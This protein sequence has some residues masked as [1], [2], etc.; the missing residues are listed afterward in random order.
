MFT[1]ANQSIIRSD[2]DLQ[3][4]K[5][6]RKFEFRG[7]VCALALRDDYSIPKTQTLDY[8]LHDVEGTPC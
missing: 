7:M 5:N 8:Q 1:I 4:A 3:N 2:T 6:I